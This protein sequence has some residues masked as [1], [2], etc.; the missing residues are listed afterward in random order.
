M[1]LICVCPDI[2]NECPA[3]CSDADCFPWCDY[4]RND[5]VEDGTN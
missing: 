5:G 3:L 1:M 4:L 2:E